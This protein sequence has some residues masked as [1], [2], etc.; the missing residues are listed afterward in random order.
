MA[1]AQ[2]QTGAKPNDQVWWKTPATAI[3]I[4]V[5]ILAIAVAAWSWALSYGQTS[6]QNTVNEEQELVTLVGDIAQ[7]PATVS[8]ESV[9][10]NH[11]PGAFNNAKVGSQLTELAEGEESA[12][13]IDRLRG[14]GV[15]TALEYYETG[16][17]LLAADSDARAL[18]FFARAATPQA[19]PRT[20]ANALRSEAILLYQLGKVAV[21]ERDDAKAEAVFEGLREVPPSAQADNIATSFLT[22]AGYQASIDCATALSEL[23]RAEKLI[24]H[25]PGS[26]SASLTQQEGQDTS[27]LSHYRCLTGRRGAKNGASIGLGVNVIAGTGRERRRSRDR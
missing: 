26:S 9:T 13:L 18:S 12:N 1:D 20:H 17:G 24:A 5:S 19:D 25:T 11:E 27:D 16:L 15:V 10:F 4:F 14:T 7:E 23:Y 6:Q 8:Q 21:A 3:P 2:K 22:D